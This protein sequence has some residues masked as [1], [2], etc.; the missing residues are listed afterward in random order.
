LLVVK[1]QFGQ[2]T[3]RRD[4]GDFVFSETTLR[5][6]VLRLF[7]AIDLYRSLAIVRLGI[8]CSHFADRPATRGNLLKYEQERKHEALWH[9]MAAVRKKYGVDALRYGVELM[10]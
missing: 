9:R 5:D 3:K 7:E 1:Y 10:G 4:T 6:K 8:A 2:K